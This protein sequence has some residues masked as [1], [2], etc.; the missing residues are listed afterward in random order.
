MK[1]KISILFLLLLYIHIGIDRDLDI[2]GLRKMAG[3]I[4]LCGGAVNI[5]NDIRMRS[6][7]P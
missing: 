4:L 7:E 6:K 5:V 2:K 1:N 3:L